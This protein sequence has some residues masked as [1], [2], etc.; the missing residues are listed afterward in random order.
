MPRSQREG[1]NGG[2]DANTRGLSEM[3]SG[4][5]QDLKPC[6]FPLEVL[7]VGFSEAGMQTSETQEEEDGGIQKKQTLR[8]PT[9]R[10]HRERL[11]CVHARTDL[12]PRLGSQQAEELC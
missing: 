12:H 10:A 4:Y 6:I 2:G 8:L 9:F 3:D 5:C 7:T 11:G 1:G